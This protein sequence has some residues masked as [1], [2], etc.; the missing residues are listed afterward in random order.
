MVHNKAVC[1]GIALYRFLGHLG[2]KSTTLGGS[3]LIEEKGMYIVLEPYSHKI[4]LFI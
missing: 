1:Y 3:I 4:K 2:K